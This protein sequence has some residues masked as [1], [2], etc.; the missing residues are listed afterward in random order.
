MM[1]RHM[2]R[3]RQPGHLRKNVVGNDDVAVRAIR[4]ERPIGGRSYE[5]RGIASND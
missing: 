5:G 3:Q 1:V 2:I 4:D